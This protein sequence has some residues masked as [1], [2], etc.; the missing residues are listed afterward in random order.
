MVRIPKGLGILALGSQKTQRST[1][2][3]P[4]P[5]RQVN[6]QI[7]LSGAGNTLCKLTFPPSRAGAARVSYD[8]PAE[9]GISGAAKDKHKFPRS[10]PDFRKVSIGKC[11]AHRGGAVDAKSSRFGQP[12]ANVMQTREAH[13]RK[14]ESPGR[15]RPVPKGKVS[16]GESENPTLNFCAAASFPTS[17][18]S[19]SAER[20]WEPVV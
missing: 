9:S 1:F 12:R 11:N 5:F 15:G 8:F 6:G 19:D 13:S 14:R 20:D 10:G 2:A 17:E 4:R 3:Q 7:P 18:R 16:I